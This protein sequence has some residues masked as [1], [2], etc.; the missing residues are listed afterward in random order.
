[1]R[2]LV[3][4]VHHWNP[5]GGGKHASLR[6]DFLPRKEGL[7][8]QLLALRRLCAI[9]GTINFS[10]LHFEPVNNA[11]G[12]VIDIKLITDGEHTVMK[13]LDA[14]YKKMFQ[15]VATKPRDGFHLGFEAQ[16]YLASCLEE[17]YDL[18]C[19]LEDDLVINDPLFFHKII[20]FNKELGDKKLVLPHRVEFLP[21]PYYIQ[22]LYIDGPVPSDV[23]KEYIPDPAKP[24][25]AGTA[26]GKIKYE[27]PLNPHSGCFFLT[28]AQLKFWKEQS[29]WQDGDISFI[30]PLESAA[31]LGI[32][33]NFITYKP[34][35]SYS[36]WIEI[37]HWGGSF[38]TQLGPSEIS[39]K[40]KEK[41]I[42][43]NE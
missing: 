20:W 10:S 7:Q 19:Y 15:E 11:L 12:H 24:I 16:K 26:A 13:Y 25:V 40:S 23:L 4:I 35:L 27:S 28:H 42:L 9:Q 29:S 17:K 18:Y 6:K 1:M 22:K 34:T 30:S 8:K 36:A 5:L 21:T 37:Q 2:I 39:E 3:A 32:I 31:T 14:P 38:I 43:K 41:D 33:K